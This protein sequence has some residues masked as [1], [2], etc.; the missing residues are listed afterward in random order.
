M[1]LEEVLRAKGRVLRP[2]KGPTPSL[3]LEVFLEALLLRPKDVYNPLRND[4]LSR[5]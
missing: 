5:T 4:L 2:P 3:F 1:F